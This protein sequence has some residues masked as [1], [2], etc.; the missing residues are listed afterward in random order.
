MLLSHNI[1]NDLQGLDALQ[2][3]S[4]VLLLADEHTKDLVHL[5]YP[6]LSIP[7][8]EEHKNL[9]S[10]AKIWDFLHQQ[11]ATRST[12]LICIGGGALTDMGGFAAATYKRGIP[13]INI[14]TTLLAMVD[15]STGGKTGFDYNGIKNE[16][17][18]FYSPQETL[19]CTELLQTLPI[20]ELLS[21]YAEMLKH[22]LIANEEEFW[23]LLQLD[24]SLP[25]VEIQQELEERIATS[26]AIKHTITEQ[27]P[28]E[29]GIRKSL[30]FGHTIG[31]ALEARAMELGRS[32]PHGYAIMQGMVAELYLSVTEKGLDKEVLR[33]MTH[34]MIDIYGKVGYACEDLEK[35]IAKMAQDKKN[36]TALAINFTLLRRIGQ[37]EI[38]QVVSPEKIKEALEYLFSL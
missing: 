18:C 12:L 33:L 14:P 19:I 38:N 6:S 11:Q 3:A 35:L 10:I 37:P 22:A 34:S 4:Q 9:T 27:D 29:R 8:G 23:K 25:F 21:G 30:N 7:P 2:R 26:M 20:E 13:Y 5:P 36:E 17:G 16:I 28:N 32:I 24:L 15:A 31:H 1:L